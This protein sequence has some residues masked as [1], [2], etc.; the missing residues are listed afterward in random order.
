MIISCGGDK[1]EVDTTSGRSVQYFPNMYESV[2]YETYQEGQIFPG[3]VEA[4]LPVEGTVNRGW[5]PYEY[6]D[7]NDG[8]ASA[9][10]ELTNPLPYTEEN[11][12]TGEE[13]YNI[14]CA[15]CHGK[16]GNGKG[17]LVTTE[18]ILGV[19]SYADREISQGS[20]YHVMYWGIN[21][22]GSY[23]SQTSIEERWQIAHHVDALTKDLKGQDRQEFVVVQESHDMHADEQSHDVENHEMD[24]HG[25]EMHDEDSHDGDHDDNQEENHSSTEG[26]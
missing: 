9:K 4:Q 21:Y 26:E 1:N 24:E 7:T 18:K 25:A 11:L 14:Y 12:A 16:K 19:P 13:L 6:E 17:H 5:M 20:I 15:I 8:Y 22:M 23:A 10:A 2:G 3:N